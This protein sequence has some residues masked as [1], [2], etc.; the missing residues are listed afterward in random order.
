MYVDE[1]GHTCILISDLVYCFREC[2]PIIYL[3]ISQAYAHLLFHLLNHVDV[4]EEIIVDQKFCSGSH[5]LFY[6]VA[7]KY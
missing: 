2:I 4:I 7:Y 3:N 5:K 6:L 1:I